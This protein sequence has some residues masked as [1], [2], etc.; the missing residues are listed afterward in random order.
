MLM[1]HWKGAGNFTRLLLPCLSSS[2]TAPRAAHRFTAS[3]PP[4]QVCHLVNTFGTWSLHI[5]QDTENP[6]EETESTERV[7]LCALPS[8]T[9]GSYLVQASLAPFSSGPPGWRDGFVTPATTATV[10][11]NPRDHVYKDLW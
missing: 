4:R 8:L 3:N 11:S 7:P 1:H 5:L 6:W 9:S 2:R 10:F